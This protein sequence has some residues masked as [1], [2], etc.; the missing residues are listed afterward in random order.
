MK[1]ILIFAVM[2]SFSM[3]CVSPK[4]VRQSN[5]EKFVTSDIIPF[6]KAYREHF[7]DDELV[8]RPN[9]SFIVSNDVEL[10]GLIADAK[11]TYFEENYMI[12]GNY[13]HVI[14][15]KGTRGKIVTVLDHDRFALQFSETDTIQ[16]IFQ[17]NSAGQLYVLGAQIDQNPRLS[18][19]ILQKY[20]ITTEKYFT[21][22]GGSNF[23]FLKG[24]NTCKLMVDRNLKAETVIL[25]GLTK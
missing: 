6:T 12:E 24:K 11:S 25:E 10:I 1:N 13:K 15:R 5:G 3:S 2:C 21:P 18:P 9:A 19:G 20:P 23:F 22:Y 16:L 8:D 14:I 7:T 4:P 17:L